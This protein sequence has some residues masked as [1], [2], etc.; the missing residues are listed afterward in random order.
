MPEDP[1]NTLYIYNM[2]SIP[3]SMLYQPHTSQKVFDYMVLKHLLAFLV[4]L[5]AEES[6][7]YPMGRKF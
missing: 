2:L 1:G 3:Q 5:H 4:T 6:Y 7:K